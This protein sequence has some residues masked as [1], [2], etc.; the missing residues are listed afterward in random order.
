MRD[1]ADARMRT[2]RPWNHASQA[3]QA[4]MKP[5]SGPWQMQ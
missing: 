5:Y 3:S 4:I 1:E 2:Q